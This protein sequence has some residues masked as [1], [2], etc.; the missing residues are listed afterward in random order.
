MTAKLRALV[1]VLLGD[2][3]LAGALR[4]QLV[5]VEGERERAR[6]FETLLEFAGSDSFTG[7]P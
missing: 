4:Q 1:D 7:G 3:K 6:R 5:G 2:E